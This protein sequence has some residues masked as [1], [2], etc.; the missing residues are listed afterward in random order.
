LKSLENKKWTRPH[1]IAAQGV[2]T[3]L[4][5]VRTIPIPVNVAPGYS[6]RRESV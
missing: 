6:K 5:Y 4:A 2:V 1:L 3:G